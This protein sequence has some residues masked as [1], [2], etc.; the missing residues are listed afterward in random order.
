MRL[1]LKKDVEHLGDAGDVVNVKDGYGLNY[2]IPQGLALHATASSVR[3]IQH[4]KRLRE[5]QVQAAKRSAESLA[6]KFSGVELEFV[7]RA[8]EDGRLFGSVTNRQIEE[9]LLE[10][11][12]EVNRRR[13]LLNEPIRKVGE[14]EV[15]IRLH[16]D[17]KALVKV[18]VVAE[19]TPE[20]EAEKESVEGVE[21]AEATEVTTASDEAEEKAES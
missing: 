4:E 15:P 20:E 11:G 3:A 12:I 9:G 18:N 10:K 8:G 2:L 6:S 14:Y 7:M 16:Q 1:I 13:I 19:E 5:A 17:V 21:G